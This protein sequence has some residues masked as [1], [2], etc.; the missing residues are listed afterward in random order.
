MSI[1]SNTQDYHK[2][3]PH[4]NITTPLKKLKADQKCLKPKHLLYQSKNP[5]NLLIKK[6]HKELKVLRYTKMKKIN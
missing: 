1:N 2:P 6:K 4:K 3:L 5:K